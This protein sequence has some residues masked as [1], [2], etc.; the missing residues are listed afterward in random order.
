MGRVTSNKYGEKGRRTVKKKSIKTKS[1][2]LSSKRKLAKM[3]KE[4]KKDSVGQDL[5]PQTLALMSPDLH[6]REWHFQVYIVY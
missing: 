2:H 6:L 4:Q 1:I 5:A 3:G